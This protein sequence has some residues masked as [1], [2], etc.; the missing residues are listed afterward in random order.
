MG[1]RTNKQGRVTKKRTN[2]RVIE[3]EMNKQKYR[4]WKNTFSVN[5]RFTSKY[6][7]FLDD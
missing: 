1:K 7:E 4:K 6:I 3:T 5:S 2:N